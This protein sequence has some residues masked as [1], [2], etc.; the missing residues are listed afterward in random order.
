MSKKSRSEKK[1]AAPAQE[2]NSGVSPGI[3]LYGRDWGEMTDLAIELTCFREGLSIADGGLG[4][5]EHFWRIVGILWPVGCRRPFIRNPW[6]ERMINAWCDHRFVSVSG[7]ASSSKTDTSAVWAIVNWLCAP[8][9]TKV[10]VTS[11]TLRESRKRIWGSVEE[12]WLA[13]DPEV[14]YVGKL[15]TSF[16]I[17][18]LSEASGMKASEKCG[19]ELIPGERKREKEATG[20]IQGIKNQRMFMIADELPELSPAIMNAVMQNWTS[21]PYVQGIGLGNPTSFFD[22]HGVFSTPKEGWKSITIEDLEWPTIYGLAIRFD[23]RQSPNILAGDDTLFPWLPTAKRLQE[24]KE[25]LGENSFGFYRQWVGWFPPDSA[26]QTVFSDTDIVFYGGNITDIEWEDEPV[27]LAGHDPGFSTDGDRSIAYFGWL[28]KE[29]ST[30]LSVLLLE[31]Y[32]VLKEDMRDKKTPRNIQI[33]REYKRACKERGIEPSNA[34]ADVSGSP[35][36]GDIVASEWSPEVLR[37]QFGGKSTKSRVVKDRAM[38]KE[39]YG[40]RVTELWFELSVYLRQGQ[41]RGICA[42][43]A[44]ELTARKYARGE[45][46][47]A[48]GGVI[49]TVESKRKMK[50]RTGKS[51]DVADGAIVLFEVARAR[52]GFKPASGPARGGFAKKKWNAF[53][54][55]TRQTRGATIRSLIYERGGRLPA[56]RIGTGAGLSL[57]R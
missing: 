36:Y 34:G 51:P 5:A 8:L 21:V 14:S 12:Y 55:K 43:L 23:A 57:V 10:M 6:S 3:Q 29:K 16:G 53:G 24:A 54:K 9:I 25:L 15:V 32:E 13:L 18:R 39:T 1:G 20:K 2:Y 19:I 28:G 42:D 7:C 41:V 30:G 52:H 22:A 50:G 31:D 27:Q 38:A 48:E 26:E 40:N 49:I 56:M 17:I 47:S 33:A 4:K 45:T 11:T 44:N 35:A 37:V 46:P